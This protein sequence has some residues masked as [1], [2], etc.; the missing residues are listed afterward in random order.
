MKLYGAMDLHSTNRVTVL[1]NEHDEVV[2][3]KRL[4]NDLKLILE[5]LSPYQSSIEGLVVESTYNWYWLV[6]G[7]MEQG[8]KV[9][10]ANTA[11]IQQYEGL[12]YTDD[13]SDARWLAHI[14]RLGVLPEGYIYPKQERAVRDLL[15]KRGQL[16]RQKTA[17]LLSIQNIYSRNTGAS[18]SANRIKQLTAQEVEQMLTAGDVALAV[19]ANLSVMRCLE[20]EIKTLERIVKERV[21]LRAGFR[22][23]LTV[24][25]IG[26]T[27]ALTIMLET[28]AIR[29]FASVGNFASYCRCVGSQ[30]LSNGKRKGKG[31]T[32]NGNKY[33]SWAFVE[34]ANF[35][36]RYQPAIRRFY[37]RK[38]AKTNGIVAI[39]AVAH[40][41][42]R[43]CYHV[44]RDQVAFDV[45]KAFSG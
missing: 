4:A 8:Y 35:A 32:K 45:T 27:L 5:Q 42:A 31:N 43:A 13:D 24:N 3:R 38:K 19:K 36:V 41:L 15:R 16:V 14:F 28:G 18:I 37:Q 17:N 30:K 7:L 12:K 34:A 26:K 20:T 33:L 11:A 6:D 9:H 1:I 29:R 25:G 40:K 44:M 22:Y 23:L 21:Q 39:K 10:L 2:Y